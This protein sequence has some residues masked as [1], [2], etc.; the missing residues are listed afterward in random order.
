MNILLVDDEQEVLEAVREILE[1]DNQ[2][3]FLATEPKEALEILNEG[4]I[5]VII[6]DLS[7]PEMS[8][9]YFIEIAKVKFPSIPVVVLSAH[10]DSEEALLNMGV[11][12]ALHK[13][14]EIDLLLGTLRELEEKN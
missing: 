7:M 9:Q 14:P 1:T 6:T 11:Y 10:I 3:I 4:Q 13:P 12:K 5:E 8:G 2:Q